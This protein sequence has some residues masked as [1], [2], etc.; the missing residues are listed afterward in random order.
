MTSESDREAEWQDR[1]DALVRELARTEV[2]LRDAEDQRELSDKLASL[3]REFLMATRRNAEVLD[4]LKVDG[5]VGAGFQARIRSQEEL[6]ELERRV[7]CALANE[8]TVGRDY[9]HIDDIA[10]FVEDSV[11][12]R[13]AIRRDGVG[14]LAAIAALIRRRGF[15]RGCS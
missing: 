15:C 12:A 9:A 4:R 1:T 5:P 8:S 3:A 2:R 14:G 13:A 10:S 6:S 7:V 11:E